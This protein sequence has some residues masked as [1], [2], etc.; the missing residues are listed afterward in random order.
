M[1]IIGDF[2]GDGVFCDLFFF[3]LVVLLVRNGL[4][5]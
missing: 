3:F 2:I 5:H 4:V 1:K